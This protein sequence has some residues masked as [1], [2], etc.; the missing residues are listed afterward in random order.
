MV[1]ALRDHTRRLA[2]ALGVVGLL[3][4]QYA[5]KGD[6]ILVLEVNPRASRTVPFVAKATG[7]PL[8]RLA[9]R[10]MVGEK[11]EAMGLP[12][13]LEPL[14]VSVKKPVMP[15]DRFPGEDLLLGPEMRSTGEVMGI[16]RDLGRAFLKA[17]IADPGGGELPA[18]GA[19]FISVRDRDK[20][21]AVWVAKRLVELG[22]EVAATAG[23]ARLFE[24]SGIRVRRVY[25]VHEG[26]PN[27]VDLI[28]DGEIRLVIN[29]PLGRPSRYDEKAIRL[30]ALERGVPCVTTMSGAQAAMS[31]ME[32]LRVGGLDVSALQDRLPPAPVPAR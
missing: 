31:A 23:T 4:V 26:S 3:N 28:R 16:D 29:T 12:L 19:V 7:V 15:F 22:Y 21:S 18:A 20:R 1:E 9:A 10:V 17:L 2:R 11:L 13:D 24:L 30:A 6:T 32:A 8:A 25:K 14:Q 5:I 27:A